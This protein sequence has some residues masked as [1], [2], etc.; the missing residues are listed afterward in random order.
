MSKEIKSCEECK[1]LIYKEDAKEITVKDG[2]VGVKE[3]L[4]YYCKTHK[5]GYDWKKVTI[6]GEQY[7]KG[8]GDVQVDKK[9]KPI[10]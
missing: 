4:E 10:K 5:P 7:Y 6:I 2:C 9:G 1:C 8:M 3:K